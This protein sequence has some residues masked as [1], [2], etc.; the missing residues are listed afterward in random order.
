MPVV[1]TTTLNG[2]RGSKR[3][4]M[5]REMLRVDGVSD[6]QKKQL[7]EA[8]MQLYGVENASLLVRSLINDYLN[9]SKNNINR[10]SKADFDN[11]TRVVLK[12]P[13]G[14]LETA[15]SY[16]DGR[17]SDRN[18]YLTSIILRE[19]GYPQ[20]QGDEIEVLRRSN[21]ELSK[22]GTN[23]N[24]ISRA[25]NILVKSGNGRMPEIGKKLAGLRREINDHT[26]K[27]LRVLD[28]GTVIYESRGSG[29]LKPKK[30]RKAV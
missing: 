29:K 22:I 12:L 10:L 27:V 9:K 18:Y 5:T 2:V 1:A 6:A 24:Q 23:L 30:A 13:L 15:D 17:I 28:A 8:A 3:G 4:A 7:Q 20:L 19:F 21:Y 11:K 14:I 16:S 25:M 26:N